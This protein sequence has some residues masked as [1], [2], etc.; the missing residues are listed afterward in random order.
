MTKFILCVIIDSIELIGEIILKSIYEKIA[1][2]YCTT[3]EEVE[4][5]M[6]KAIREAHADNENNCTIPTNEEFIMLLVKRVTK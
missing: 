3:V 4:K 1:E 5:E 6:Q 2:K